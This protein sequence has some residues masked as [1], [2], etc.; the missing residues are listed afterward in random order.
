MESAYRK[1]AII[2]GVT[3]VT[4]P[5]IID[6]PRVRSGQS[7]LLSHLSRIGKST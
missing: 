6:P 5:Q 1:W 2:R 4:L 7:G 3:H